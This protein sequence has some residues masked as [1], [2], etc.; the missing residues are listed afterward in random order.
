MKVLTLQDVSQSLIFIQ[1]IDDEFHI[2]EELLKIVPMDNGCK[3]LDVFNVVS[4][5]G[6]FD[7]L[8]CVVTDGCSSYDRQK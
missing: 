4:E 3:G 5:C 6:G 1:T 8:S 7:K 2:Y